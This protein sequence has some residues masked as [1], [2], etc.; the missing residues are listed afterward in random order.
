MA[1]NLSDQQQP[2]TAVVMVLQNNY[3]KVQCK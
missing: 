2:T 3:K 1:V